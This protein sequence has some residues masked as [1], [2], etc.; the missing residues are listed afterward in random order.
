MSL[1]T[2]KSSGRNDGGSPVKGSVARA[3]T[4]IE[5]LVATALFAIL[6]LAL[7]SISNQAMEIWTRN[8]S[9]SDLREAARTAINLMGSEM[10]QATLPLY[11][12]E[13]AGLQFAINP[14]GL[15][16]SFKNR[17]AVFWQAPIA[18]SRSRGNLAA[19]GYF[20]R[21]LNGNNGRLCRFFVNPDDSAYG[22]I[23][24]EWVDSNRLDLKAPGDDANDLRGLFLENV[25]GMWVSAYDE[26]GAELVDYDS[27]VQQRLP[28]RVEITLALLDK[29]GAERVARGFDL[30]DAGEF[31]FTEF[32]AELKKP[33]YRSIQASVQTVTI[34]VSFLF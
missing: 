20:V 32:M 22:S 33:Q 4:V 15:S 25:P 10:R 14:P 24:G 28:S 5:L 21:R 6:V 23:A 18:T 2:P 13:P 19:V 16:G 9:K 1:P 3:F 27:R 30:P 17:D 34:N 12:A 7:A 11:R 31:S 8:E 26:T 29:R